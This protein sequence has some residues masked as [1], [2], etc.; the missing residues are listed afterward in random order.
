M[1][2]TP[3]QNNGGA[4]TRTAAAGRP[5]T[6]SD[7]VRSLRL[8]DRTAAEPRRSAWLP[9][10]LCALLAAAVGFLG[11]RVFT[12]SSSPATTEARPRPTEKNVPAGDNRAGGV[13]SSGDV[14]LES[15]G[16]IIPAHQIQVSPIEVS[17]R[18]IKLYIE[19]GRRFKKGEVLAELDSSL[20]QARVDRARSM[21]KQAESEVKQAEAGLLR[22]NAD[23]HQLE[24]KYRQ[25]AYEWDRAQNLVAANAVSREDR[26]LKRANYEVSEANVR[27]GKAAVEQADATV[28]RTRDAV[29]TAR[30]ELRDAEWRLDNCT[31]RA[32]VT[33][34][35]LTKKAEEGNFINPVAFNVSANLCDMADLSDLEVTLDIQERDIA[36]VKEGQRCRIRSEAFPDRI[37]EGTVSRLMPIADRAKGAVPVRVKVVVPREEEGVYLK[38]EMGAV[39]SFLKDREPA[40]TSE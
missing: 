1:N 6:L 39:V 31:I 23:L 15:K 32:P 20:Y 24:A 26:D 38:P 18:V 19:E 5:P 28:Q 37:Y 27:V 2:P 3:E 13:A 40:R 25:A 30:A 10:T 33:G 4:P 22:A 9:W 35:I 7:R 14:A 21:V 11:W 17:G 29:D 16:Y 12:T 8:P 36:K 34:T